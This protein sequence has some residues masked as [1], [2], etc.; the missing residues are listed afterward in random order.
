MNL[1]GKRSLFSSGVAMACFGLL[2]AAVV[3]PVFAESTA[4]ES[5]GAAATN[6]SSEGAWSHEKSPQPTKK[7]WAEA[8]SFEMTRLH[9]QRAKKCDA[10]RIREWLKVR[11]HGVPTAAIQLVGGQAKNVYYWI[12]PPSEETGQLP[13]DGEVVLA[14]RQGDVRVIQWW[15]FGPGYDGPLTVLGSVMLQQKWPEGVDEPS[16]VL[17][18]VLQEP[19]RTATQEGK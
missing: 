17:S 4:S 11:C 12:Q 5:T 3:A 15:T 6:A 13:G 18:D 10:L 8:G 16:F 14:V 7:E 1:T 2:S 19:I 9:G